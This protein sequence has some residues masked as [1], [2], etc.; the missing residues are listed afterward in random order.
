M[1]EAGREIE[2]KTVDFASEITPDCRI[3]VPPEIAAQVPAGQPI[4]VVLSWGVG[5]DDAAWRSE[6]RSRFAA[7]HAAED[8]VYE[9]LIDDP[10]TR[11]MLAFRV[12]SCRHGANE[13]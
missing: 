1:M 3:K 5:E 2:M 12:T 6:G 10:S 7:A 9:S 13:E 11:V 4:H 8:S